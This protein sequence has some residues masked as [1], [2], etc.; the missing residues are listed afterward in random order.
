M[1]GHTC[2]FN[3]GIRK[4][5]EYVQQE[6][7][8]VYYLYARRTN[9]GPIRRDVNALWDLAPHD[10]AIVNYLRGSTPQRASPG[11]GT[12]L[13]NSAGGGGLITRDYPDNGLAHVHG[14]GPTSADSGERV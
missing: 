9:L 1:V 13:G 4:V 2:V 3:A 5:K 12:V 10:I 11:G 14:S 6:S 8:R 7:G